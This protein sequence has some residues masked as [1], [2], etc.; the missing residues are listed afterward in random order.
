[1]TRARRQLSN[2]RHRAMSIRDALRKTWDSLRARQQVHN[3]FLDEVRLKDLRVAVDWPVS[4]IAGP[5]WWGR[6]TVLF[7]CAAACPP[8]G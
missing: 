4:G 8:V 3:D 1:M 5:D 7:G 6:S 2:K